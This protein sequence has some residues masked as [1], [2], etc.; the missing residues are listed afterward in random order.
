MIIIGFDKK[1]A[2]LIQL[3][4]TMQYLLVFIGGGL[5]SLARFGIGKL[6]NSFYHGGF[7]LGT[8]ISNLL[9]C[10]LMAVVV[11][12]FSMKSHYSEWIQPFILIGFCGGFSTF[13]TFGNETFELLDSG[14]HV[15]AITNIL[16]SVVVGVGLIFLIRSRF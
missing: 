13:S 2:S 16:L 9:A 7:P 15:L 6:S 12:S 3:F 11:L 8:L 14:Q 4:F 5:G 10:L 1:N